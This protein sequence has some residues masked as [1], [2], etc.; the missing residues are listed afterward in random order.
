M[1]S[2]FKEMER[3][4]LSLLTPIHNRALSQSASP[5]T[6]RHWFLKPVPPAAATLRLSLPTQFLLTERFP[7]SAWE[8]E[9]WATRTAGMSQRRMDFGPTCRI[10]LRQRSPDFTSERTDR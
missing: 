2:R 8:S 9:H 5:R 4:R 10:R 3:L 6:A 1:F 7:R